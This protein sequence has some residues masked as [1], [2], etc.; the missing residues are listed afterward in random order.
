ME[1][2]FTPTA[3]T[4]GSVV[5][6]GEYE[7]YCDTCNLFNTKSGD[8]SYL[9]CRFKISIGPQAGRLIT[10]RFTVTNPNEDAVRIGHEQLSRLCKAIDVVAVK[11]TEDLVFK[12]CRIKVDVE[13][14]KDNGNDQNRIKKFERLAGGPVVVDRP[15]QEEGECPF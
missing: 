12:V 8:G 2:S 14:R 11:D 3:A 7:A 9:Q 15:K 6:P 13:K 4:S 5:P 1:F 10:E